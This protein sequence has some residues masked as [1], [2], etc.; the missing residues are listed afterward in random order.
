MRRPGLRSPGRTYN[1]VI[2]G[3]TALA[4]LAMVGVSYRE[5]RRYSRAN[6]D[7]ARTRD[8]LD[9]VDRLL[10]DLM[11]AEAAQRGYLLTGD[12]R[13]L[14]P[15]NLAV[16]AVPDDLS[17]LRQRLA[18]R[19]GEA[20]NLARLDELTG[21]RLAEFRQMVEV[22]S[23][24][25]AAPAAAIFL[26][27]QGK[28]T[29]D[30]IRA[31]CTEIRQRENAGQSQ[32]SVDGEAAARTALLVTAAGSLVLL[33]LFAVG[34]EPGVVS[35]P[36]VRRN[37]WPVRYGAAVL[38][39]AA[40]FG[41]RMML[42][43]L[44][45]PTELAF[46]IFLPAVLFSAWF[47]GFRPGALSILLSALLSSYYLAE[48]RGSLLIRHET[49]QISLLIFVVV[50]FGVALLSDA[51]RRSVGLARHAELA[52]RE[53][54]QRFETTL[55]SIGDAVV[56]TDGEGKVTFANR[57][58]LGLLGWPEKQIAGQSLDG[59]FRIVNEFTRT[60]VESPVARVLREGCIAGLA[61]HTILIARDGRET[62]I[63][64]SA[65]PILGAEGDIRGTVLVF[66]DISDRRRAEAS[67]RLLVSIVESS[68]DAIVSNDLNGIVTTWNRGAERMFGYTAAEMIGQPIAM[69]AAPGREG[70]IGQ[71]LERIHQGESTALS[72]TVRRTKYGSLVDV[73]I[74]ASPLYDG[75]GRIA[76][77]SRIARDIT[78]R[79]RA[80]AALADLNGRLAKEL[81]DTGR[82]RELSI[83]L[84]E[85][86]ELAPQLQQVLETS[87]ELL[88]AHKG[89]VQIHDES[90]GVL[91]MMAHCGF[92]REFLEK[93]AAVPPGASLFDPSH[94]I[95]AVTSTSLFG[96]D[97]KPLGVLSIV[98][99]QPH[100][101]SERDLHLLEL[102]ARQAE[103]VI[104]R[105][106]FDE[107]QVELRAKEQALA[108]EK[109]LRETEAELARMERA[110]SVGELAASIA[111]EVN[112]PLAGVVT[113]AEAGV[114]WLDGARPNIEEAKQSLA[115]IARDANRAGAVISRIR[116]F[117]KKEPSPA[118]SLDIN[119]VI[120]EAVAL[121]G[122]EVAKRRTALRMDLEA[123]LPPVRGD[124]I[125]LQQVIVNLIMN[126][127]E[128][129][130]AAGGAKELLVVSQASQEPGSHAGVL[131]A[132]R[133]TGI[134]I[135]P[136]D[137][138]RI[139][140]AFF[141][142]KSSGMGMGLSISRSILEAHGGRIWAE[143]NQGPG[144]TVR[145]SLPAGSAGEKVS[146]AGRPA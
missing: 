119:D 127:V 96:S 13:Y 101:P 30:A 77:A 28:R 93:C 108:A 10:S 129:M 137:T 140:D 82:L 46:S 17:L 67:S 116:R 113:N 71:N 95:D 29:M 55:A 47:G 8:A 2:L 89:C 27:D 43:P 64:D 14:D 53:E 106:Q 12:S 63:D 50:G 68:D 86:G 142:T 72:D 135:K 74:T 9:S 1:T 48:P 76:G 52:E 104:E 18:A 19:T 88:G 144:L 134:G 5:W 109:A 41:L 131:V 60:E 45:G 102:L 31:L 26:S 145:F 11:D 73:S 122:A 81:A 130:A 85:S 99:P 84:L 124:R 39:T 115:L 25:G 138:Q 97:R 114:R 16:R 107:K 70:E 61:N 126:G 69:L 66:R 62:P 105:Q 54:R 78:G 83:R 4:L 136:E 111:H 91:R 23:Q 24:Q 117:L 103:R 65:A 32:A 3:A 40:A 125:Q 141:T 75:A 6:T 36:Q 20:G 132:V 21:Q 121:T 15:Y 80:E 139:F 100:R 123:G 59:V 98:Y 49:D 57:I 38:A 92:D 44:I 33:F 87:I 37:P 90:G 133:D 51:Q 94:G 35:D 118:A 120:R 79:K 146:V 42:T 112:Q 34:T 128:A 58:A 22:R 110:L 143:P 7:A 56:A